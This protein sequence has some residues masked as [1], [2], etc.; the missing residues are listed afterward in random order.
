MGS[1]RPTNGDHEGES[2]GHRLIV[3]TF[4][5]PELFLLNFNVNKRS[6]DI[7]SRWEAIGNHS[8][9][10][11][12]KEKKLLLATCWTDPPCIASYRLN[13][14]GS[15]KPQAKLVGRQTVKSR[16][17]YVA[18]HHRLEGGKG[19]AY[20]AGG[21]SGEVLGLQ[22]ETGELPDTLQEM[23]YI[24]GETNLTEQGQR[25]RGETDGQSNKVQNT[26]HQNG[27]ES[28]NVLDFGGLR[29]GAHSIDLSPDGKMMYVADIGRNCVWVHK[30]DE[31]GLI[32]STQKVISPRSNDGPRH[33]WP[34]PGGKFVYVLQEHS[35][36]VDVFKVDS[37]KGT[38][39]WVQ[40]VRIIPEDQD[41]KLFWAD[42]VRIVASSAGVPSDEPDLLVASTR[43]L[44]KGTKGYVALFRLTS[45]GLIDAKE[46]EDRRAWLDMWQ[47][48]TSGGWANAV[49]PCY[50]LLH[51]P[52]PSSTNQSRSNEGQYM[53]LTDSEEGLVMILSIETDINKQRKHIVEVA[54]V[55]LGESSDGNIRGAATAVW[56]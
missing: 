14:L 9:L 47:S 46:K 49:E 55:S 31:E 17:G 3:G 26:A 23:N 4:N 10:A 24:T 7:E 41:E 56:L 48:P 44:E 38:L 43:G 37:A 34:H 8:W 1:I 45:E 20:T 22:I 28:G 6:L 12:D 35:S 19:R 25:L 39:E 50:K 27:K 2:G 15:T 11:L 36:M 13:A 18:V 51:D 32:T 30:L 21:P 42:E 33:V 29:H 54:R 40:G 52:Q 53:A 16:S 5:T